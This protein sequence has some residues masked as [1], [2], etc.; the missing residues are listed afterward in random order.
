MKTVLLSL[1]GMATA[2]I[3]SKDLVNELKTIEKSWEAHSLKTNPLSKKTE[4]ELKM[5]CG[6]TFYGQ[7]EE[8]TY[9]PE[10]VGAPKNFDARKGKF[11]SCI[12]PVRNQARCGSC[13][14]FGSAEALSDRFCIEGEDVILSPQWSVS[15]NHKEMGCGGGWLPSTW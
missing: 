9:K 14:A 7:V 10:D 12:H 11:S 5:M 1:V 15:C 6:T 2:D 13:W 8:S 4:E 3:M